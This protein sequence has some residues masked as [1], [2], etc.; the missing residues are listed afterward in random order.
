MDDDRTCSIAGGRNRYLSPDYR[1]GRD[2]IA[3]PARRVAAN[4]AAYFLAGIFDTRWSVADGARRR[5]ATSIR[6]LPRGG[7][8][9]PPIKD[10][11]CYSFQRVGLV[12]AL[13]RGSGGSSTPEYLAGKTD[14]CNT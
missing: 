5:G 10:V 7:G 2:L 3:A 9:T 12:A 13:H 4:V 8:R 14:D 11:G 1:S 6:R